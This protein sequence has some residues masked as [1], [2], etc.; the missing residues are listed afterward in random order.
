MNKV[1][2]LTGFAILVVLSPLS[3]F[4]QAPDGWSDFNGVWNDVDGQNPTFSINDDQLDLRLSDG[5]VINCRIQ[6]WRNV[7]YSYLVLNPRGERPT[8]NYIYGYI[9][10]LNQ[11]GN[12]GVTTYTFL[13]HKDKRYMLFM[14]TNDLETM[15][16]Y[17]KRG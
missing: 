3:I 15:I 4:A 17:R 14:P 1:F 2:L 12:A 6:T 16:T 7:N 10:T 11:I 8:T 5:S 9:V 13:F